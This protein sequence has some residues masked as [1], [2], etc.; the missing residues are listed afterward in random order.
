MSIDCQIHIAQIK[1][2]FAI[3][4][5]NT[6]YLIRVIIS[7]DKRINSVVVYKRGRPFDEISVVYKLIFFLYCTIVIHYLF[8]FC[9]FIDTKKATSL[10]K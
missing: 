3:G 5:K 7:L 10:M 2:L 6:L 4:N 1:H 9:S 8:I